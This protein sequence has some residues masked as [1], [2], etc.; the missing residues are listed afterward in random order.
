MNRVLLLGKSYHMALKRQGSH[1]SI[2]YW[3]KAELSQDT[4]VSLPP[5]SATARRHDTGDVTLCWLQPNVLAS[6][7]W[8]DMF[9]TSAI[10]RDAPWA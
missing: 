8:L 4:V 10:C 5:A 9:P 6:T 2:V 1:R 7:S 3:L